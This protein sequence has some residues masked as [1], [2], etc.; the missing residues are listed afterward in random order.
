MGVNFLF[1]L[2][3]VARVGL[4]NGFETLAEP[5][6]GGMLLGVREQLIGLRPNLT[7]LIISKLLTHLLDEDQQRPPRPFLI[8]TSL[9][10]TP[11]TFYYWLRLLLTPKAA[12]N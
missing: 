7:A 6:A 8:A 9:S 3:F 2:S 1:P 11:G 4:G 5:L 10:D 12:K